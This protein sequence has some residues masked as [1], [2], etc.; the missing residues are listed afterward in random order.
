MA[1]KAFPEQGYRACLGIIRLGQ[2]FGTERLEGAC[3]RALRFN[4]VSYRSVKSILALGLDQQ[5]ERKP[6]Q[7]TTLPFH[8]N[9]RGGDYYH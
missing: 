4:A 9:I 2:R 8:E 3:S 5:A 6:A 7:Q 1:S